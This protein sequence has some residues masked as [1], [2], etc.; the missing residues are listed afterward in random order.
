[1][2]TMLFTALKKYAQFG[3]RARRKEYW[4]FFLLNLILLIVASI[5]DGALGTSLIP[6][7][8]VFYSLTSLALLL[9]G[10][11]VYVRRLHDVNK[12]GW[13]ILLPIVGAVLL[14]AG[15]GANLAAL[16]G[17][18]PAA[19]LGAIGSIGLIGLA[20]SALASIYLFVLALTPGTRGAN[21]FGPDPKGLEAERLGEVFG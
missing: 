1:M 12:S 14:V 4:Q 17:P 20:V 5:L 15:L 10:I 13:L 2:P 11:S 16:S 19:G 8:G 3:G 7:T 6:G 21:R 18:N 9:P